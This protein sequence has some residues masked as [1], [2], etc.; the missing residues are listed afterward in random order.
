MTGLQT[1]IARL[2]FYLGNSVSGLAILWDLGPYSP[3]VIDEDARPASHVLFYAT[4]NSLV[5]PLVWS[6]QYLHPSMR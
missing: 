2:Q 6:V 3:T 5:D 1:C 4:Y